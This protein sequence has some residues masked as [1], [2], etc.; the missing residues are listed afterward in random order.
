MRKLYLTFFY[1]GCTK[2]ASGTFGTIAALIPA[3]FILKYLGIQT[4]FLLSI[5]ICIASIRVI[6]NYEKETKIHDDKHIVIDE[7]AGVFLALAIFGNTLFAFLLSFILFRM[8]DIL[9][10]S[11]IG[12]VDK[13]FKGGLGVMLDDMLAGL[14]AGLLSA[15]IY[16]ILNHFNLLQWDIELKSL[17]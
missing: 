3:F 11:I 6:D 12:I 13:K 4:L 15:V 16:G 17:F 8:F 9:K 14:F 7:V 2:K 5:L 10:P 1:S